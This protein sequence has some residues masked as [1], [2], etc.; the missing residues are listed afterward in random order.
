M[1]ILKMGASWSSK[2]LVSYITTQ[3]NMLQRLLVDDIIYELNT[4]YIPKGTP[5]VD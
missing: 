1:I 3:L 2:T 5:T 4:F